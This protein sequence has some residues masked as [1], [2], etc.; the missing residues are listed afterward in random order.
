MSDASAPPSN[1]RGALDELSDG[2]PSPPP[3]P[4]SKSL[5]GLLELCNTRGNKGTTQQGRTHDNDESEVVT[6]DGYEN[7]NDS[8]PFDFPSGPIRYTDEEVALSISA[9]NIRRRQEMERAGVF[10]LP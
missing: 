9:E 5:R 7:L 6:D 1:A 10:C 2:E 8:A 4:H 3:S